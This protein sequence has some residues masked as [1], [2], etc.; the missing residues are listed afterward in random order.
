PPRGVGVLARR[1]HVTGLADDLAALR[2]LVGARHDGG[3]VPHRGLAAAVPVAALLEAG[4]RGTDLAV[5]A[6][7][8]DVEVP[9]LTEL[10]RGQLGVPV[11][12]V[13]APAERVD[14]RVEGR[15]ALA[16]PRLAAQADPSDTVGRIVELPRELL[17]LV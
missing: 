8:V 11:L 2:I 12:V 1:G 10:R 14:H 4:R 6:N 3:V 9:R 13:P 7:Q 16:P 15:E 17:H 5:V